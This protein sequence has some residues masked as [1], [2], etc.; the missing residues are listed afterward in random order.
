MSSAQASLAGSLGFCQQQWVEYTADSL[1]GCDRAAWSC[2][3][4]LPV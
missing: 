1:H 2:T 3:A 4:E